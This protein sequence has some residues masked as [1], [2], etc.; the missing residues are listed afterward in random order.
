LRGNDLVGINVVAHDI[1]RAGENRFRHAV[2]VPR[3][4][5]IFNQ[6]SIARIT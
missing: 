3:V 4:A 2:N 1:N 6:I 5:G